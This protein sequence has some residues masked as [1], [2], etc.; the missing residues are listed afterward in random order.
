MIFSSGESFLIIAIPV[1]WNVV[2]GQSI[3]NCLFTLSLNSPTALFVKET[4]NISLGLIF[5]IST[6]YL[7]LAA[8]VVVLPAPAPAITNE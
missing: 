4:T 5:L 1:E 8:T 6:R 3:F 7:I 2:I